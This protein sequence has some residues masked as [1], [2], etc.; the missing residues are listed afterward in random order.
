MRTRVLGLCLLAALVLAAGAVIL[1]RTPKM[2]P[3]SG[4]II[5]QTSQDWGS[6]PFGNGECAV[7]NNTWNKGAAGKGFRQSVFLEEISGKNAIGWRWFAP[8]QLLAKVVSQPEIICGNKPWDAQTRPDGGFPFRAGT[9]RLTAE[10]EVNLRASGVYNMVFSLWAISDVDAPRQSI[11]HEIMIWTDRA[12]QSPA[13][14]RV[15]SMTVQG[16]AY[17]VYVEEHQKDAS[18]ANANSWTYVA[19]VA[20]RPVFRGP[21]DISAFIDYL[22]RRGTLSSAHYLTSLEFGNEICH[23]AGV[24]EIQGF[25]INLH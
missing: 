15:D 18:G 1:L 3:V 23:G 19:F 10:F 20:Q 22:L 5:T 13:G 17:D 11:T 6:I 2:R 7:V 4:Q 21:L 9:K 8:W 12:G 16:T 24:A 25:A 14:R